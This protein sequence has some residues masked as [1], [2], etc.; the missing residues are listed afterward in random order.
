MADFEV[1]G[2]VSLNPDTDT[3]NCQLCIEGGEC[4]L[5]EAYCTIDKEFLCSGCSNAHRRS[6]TTRNHPL[7]DK[8][9]MPTKAGV[10][11]ILE[12]LSEYCEKHPR[13]LIKY[14]CPEHQALLCGDCVAL[15]QHMCKMNT[16]GD[17]SKSFFGSSVHK[18]IK[19][20]IIKIADDACKTTT[21]LEKKAMDI[22]NSE[23]KDKAE[24]SDFQS[25]VI[26]SLNEKFQ[27]LTTQ[28]TTTSQ[29]YKVK[30]IH[31]QE[32]SKETEIEANGL[33]ADME[34]NVNNN[35]LLFISAHRVKMRANVIMDKLHQI[36][37]EVS[38]FP[39]YEFTPSSKF[40]TALKDPNYIG[41]YRSSSDTHGL[42]SDVICSNEHTSGIM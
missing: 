17:A 20:H 28:I 21:A 5:A 8:E 26:A 13:E 15:D 32:R 41:I 38:K 7:L 1:P 25:Q 34:E 37:E 29:E 27:K 23:R 35:V 18:D 42:S 16:I 39:T 12:N 4:V 24:V 6:K 2:R 40:N 22:D 19:S 30:L 3:P 9:N 36:E 31:L 11:Q 33:N 10:G 14:F